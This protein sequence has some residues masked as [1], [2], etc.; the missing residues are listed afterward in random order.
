MLRIDRRRMAEH[1]PYQGH[2]RCK[3]FGDFRQI[4]FGTN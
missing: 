2:P 1:P 3:I 4:D